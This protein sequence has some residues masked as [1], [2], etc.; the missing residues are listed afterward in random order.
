M[1]VATLVSSSGNQGKSCTE[2][3]TITSDFE[4]NWPDFLENQIRTNK[5]RRV[6]NLDE[7]FGKTSRHDEDVCCPPRDSE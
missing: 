3:E 1:I 7:T 6:K 4:K 2:S 5:I